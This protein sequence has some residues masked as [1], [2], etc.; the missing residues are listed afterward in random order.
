MLKLENK[1]YKNKKIMKVTKEENV[2]LYKILFKDSSNYEKWS[3]KFA[4]FVRSDYERHH[5]VPGIQWPGGL[6]INDSVMRDF[7]TWLRTIGVTVP[8]SITY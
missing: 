2:E 3:P 8:D 4:E 7:Y 5:A 6:N 1:V